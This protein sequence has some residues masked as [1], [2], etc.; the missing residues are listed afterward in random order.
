MSVAQWSADLS[1]RLEE[2]QGRREEVDGFIDGG[3]IVVWWVGIKMNFNKSFLT[4]Y[5]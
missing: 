5:K 3:L 4:S 1:P 2:G